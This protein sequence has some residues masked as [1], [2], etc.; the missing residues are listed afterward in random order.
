[1]GKSPVRESWAHPIIIGD[2]KIDFQHTVLCL[3][4]PIVCKQRTVCFLSI[5]KR[6]LRVFKDGVIIYLGINY[7]PDGVYV[8]QHRLATSRFHEVGEVLHS[9]FHDNQVVNWNQ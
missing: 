5:E 6:H 4:T 9:I 8:L 7:S 3:Q 2:S 1:M